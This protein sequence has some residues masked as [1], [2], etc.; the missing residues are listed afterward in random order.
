[1]SPINFNKTYN[2]AAVRLYRSFVGGYLDNQSGNGILLYEVHRRI[3][4]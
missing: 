3:H 1:L 2:L 4:T